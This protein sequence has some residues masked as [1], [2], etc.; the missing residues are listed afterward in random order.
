MKDEKTQTPEAPCIM[1]TYREKGVFQRLHLCDYLREL[2]EEQAE[3]AAT[4]QAEPFAP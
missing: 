4:T 1:E 3:E 2:T